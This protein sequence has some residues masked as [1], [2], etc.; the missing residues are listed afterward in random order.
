MAGVKIGLLLTIKDSVGFK[1]MNLYVIQ[2]VIVY[3]IYSFWLDL[4]KPSIMEGQ[5]QSQE[6]LDLSSINTLC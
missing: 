1:V 2:S 3:L 5:L 4:I 6:T